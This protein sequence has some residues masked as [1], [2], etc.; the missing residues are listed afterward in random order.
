MAPVIGM[1]VLMG[2]LAMVGLGLF[3]MVWARLSERHDRA[4]LGLGVAV[5]GV[6]GYVAIWLGS[7]VTAPARVLPVGQELSF[8]GVDCHLHVSVARVVQGTDLA[9]TVR[10]RSDARQAEEYPGE[11]RLVVV[12]PAGRRSAPASGMVAETLAAGDTLEREFRFSVPA[13][14]G[15]ARL[16]VSYARWLDFL[17]PGRA[18]AWVQRRTALGLGGRH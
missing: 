6:A 7:L 12:D 16:E 5:A 3:V 9:V 11:L 18:N 14:S 10:F 1:F 17:L 15:E 8:C 4:R 13:G 2:A